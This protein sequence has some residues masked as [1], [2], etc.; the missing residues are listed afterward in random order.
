MHPNIN[1]YMTNQINTTS[2]E[3]LVLMLYDGA[4]KFINKSIKALENGDLE[5]ANHNLLR[6]QN[7]VAE[8]MAGINFEAGDIAHNLYTLYEYMHYQLIQANIKKETEAARE[9]LIMINELRASWAQIL[10][11]RK[12]APQVLS[13]STAA[14]LGK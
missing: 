13:P 10:K 14:G 5:E 8:L 7:I 4:R 2:P 1:L 11:E 6:A 12:I 3:N 9:I